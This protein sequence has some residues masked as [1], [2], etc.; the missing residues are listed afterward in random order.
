VIVAK[1]CPP[2]CCLGL[3]STY[4]ATFRLATLD[5]DFRTIK[6]DSDTIKNDA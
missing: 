4:H 1:L 5:F 2:G 3:A 6:Y